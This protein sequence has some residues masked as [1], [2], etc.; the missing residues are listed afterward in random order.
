MDP[1]NAPFRL[2]DCVVHPDLGRVEG[3][4]GTVELE[5]KS[6]AVLL[7]LVEH[8]GQVVSADSLIERVWQSRPMGDNPVYG[9]IAKLRKALGDEAGKP[10]FIATVPKRGYRLLQRPE[11]VG[12]ASRSDRDGGLGPQESSPGPQSEIAS[13]AV[14]PFVYLCSD[15]EHRFLAQGLAAELHASLARVHRLRVASRRSAFSPAMQD[16]DVGEIGRRLGVQY[17]LS[18]T[19]RCDGDRLRLIIELDDAT[20]GVQLWSKGFD[21]RIDDALVLEQDIANAIV[22]EFGGERLRAEI[23]RA[24]NGTE[25][26][27][28]AWSLVQKARSYLLDY[29]AAALEAAQ[30]LLERAVQ[31]D[32]AYAAAHGA[33]GSFLAERLVNGLSSDARRDQQLARAAVEEAMRLSPGDP[34][35][36]KM[37]GSAWAYFGDADRSADTLRRAVDLAPFDFG[38]WGHLGWPLTQ[39]GREADL[40]E[41]HAVLERIVLAA[42]NHPGVP[43]WRY[44]QSVAHSCA[45]DHDAAVRR[46]LESVR[47]NP[48]FSMAWM[49]HA[50]ALGALGDGDGARQALDKGRDINQ[51]MTPQHYVAT[52]SGMCISADVAQRR[53]IGLRRIGIDNGSAVLKPQE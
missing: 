10:R 3:V 25:V 27:L 22:S 17:V 39:T 28:D 53:L 7:C 46:S 33:L 40:G 47:M 29:S 36:L 16:L 1:I 45:G 42:P 52:I 34:F 35:V 24:A 19:L 26:S 38:A 41:L 5:P 6:M 14:L 49:Q 4:D 37:C 43:Y 11:E 50:N 20:D 15:E 32:P 30:P 9:C 31:I 48:G 18:G 12:R 8:D 51:A 13:I 44:H 2:G 21:G 23:A